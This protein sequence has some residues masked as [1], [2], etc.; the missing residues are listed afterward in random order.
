MTTAQEDAALKR[1]CCEAWT[2][3]LARLLLGERFHPGGE[4]ATD[5]AAEALRLRPG[6]RVLDMGC[7]YGSALRMLTERGYVAIGL[8]LAHETALTATEIGAVVIADAE[9]PPFGERCV[10]GILMEC[11]LSLLPDKPAALKHAFHALKPGGRIAISDITVEQPL[12]LPLG[13]VAAWSA[14]VGGALPTGEY[15]SLLE[16]A[17]FTDVETACLDEELIGLIE[18]IR[19]R[20]SLIQVALTARHVDLA[21]VGMNTEQLEGVRRLI[22]LASDVVHRGGADTAFSTR[23]SRS[24]PDAASDWP[25][26]EQ[27]KRS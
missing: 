18:Q 27:A 4:R 12:P 16:E 25:P 14:C 8:D 5:L 21:S 23:S 6:A 2:N 26:V 20:I 1:A 11:V 22:A 10:D 13:E 24:R 19:R 3:P 15:I 9:C 7:G 17:G